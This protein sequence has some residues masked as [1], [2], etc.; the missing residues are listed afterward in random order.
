MFRF[1]SFFQA[2]VVS[3]ESNITGWQFVACKLS[4]PSRPSVC[5]QLSLQNGYI[6]RLP[7]VLGN[8]L[9]VLFPVS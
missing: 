8:V 5:L 1:S 9:F 3:R 2:Q 4:E 6:Y 7:V